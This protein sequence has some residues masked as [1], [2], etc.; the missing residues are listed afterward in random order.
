MRKS[1]PVLRKKRGRPPTG[2][3]PVLAI[4]LPAALRADIESWAMRQKDKPS[5]SE[6][7]R[8]LIEFA[9]AIKSKN[10][11][12]TP[13]NLNDRT[14]AGCRAWTGKQ[15]KPNTGLEVC[16]T[17]FGRD[18]IACLKR[19]V[20]GMAAGAKI[21]SGK[22][23]SAFTDVRAFYGEA[24]LC[25]HGAP[26]NFSKRR[27]SSACSPAP[28]ALRYRH[29]QFLQRNGYRNRS[30]FSGKAKIGQALEQTICLLLL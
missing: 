18:L 16:L 17:V 27:S 24:R 12:P 7:I 14:C 11:T 21:N 4:R 10:R 22:S 9:L 6:A 13:S 3:N 26:Q 20:P 30:E 25:F 23:F 28:L 8:R 19:Y 2:Q 5:R 1:I 29:R 15:R